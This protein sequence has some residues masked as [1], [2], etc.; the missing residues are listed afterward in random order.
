ML[1]L[2]DIKLNF[3]FSLNDLKEYSFNSITNNDLN[4]LSTSFVTQFTLSIN[5]FNE[6]TQDLNLLTHYNY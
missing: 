4:N 1:K 2:I 6:I 5:V 3:F